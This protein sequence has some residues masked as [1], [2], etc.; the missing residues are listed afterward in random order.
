MIAFPSSSVSFG[1]RFGSFKVICLGT[2]EVGKTSLIVRLV[3]RRG[4]A[5]EVPRLL[6]LKQARRM[7]RSPRESW[8]TLTVCVHAWWRAAG[9]H[10]SRPQKEKTITVDNK[11]VKLK[12]VRYFFQATRGRLC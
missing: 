9:A 11:P 6:G 5:H 7:G 3:V 12:I 10:V 8:K 2:I 1:S 4:G